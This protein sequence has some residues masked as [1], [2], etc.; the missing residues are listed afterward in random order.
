[1]LTVTIENADLKAVALARSFA[2]QLNARTLN[3][4]SNGNTTATVTAQFDDR[5]KGL[6]FYKTCKT[7]SS[8]KFCKITQTYLTM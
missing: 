6:E 2:T 8:M 5:E 7:A 1:M 4:Q 3:W